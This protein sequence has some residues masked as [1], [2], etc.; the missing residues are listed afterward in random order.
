MLTPTFAQRIEGACLPGVRDD[1]LYGKRRIEHWLRLDRWC[2]IGA[3]EAFPT[4]DAAAYIDT[5]LDPQPGARPA[6]VVGVRTGGGRNLKAST[7]R[8][9]ATEGET[10]TRVNGRWAK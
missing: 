1:Y 8:T 2:V 9:L 3:S 7:L 4:L 5:L 10:R 6:Y